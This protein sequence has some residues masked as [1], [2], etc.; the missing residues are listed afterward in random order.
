M[1]LR[2]KIVGAAIAASLL[3]PIL[4]F[5]QIVVP[6]PPAP[7]GGRIQIN[8]PLGGGN[9]N[10]TLDGFVTRILNEVVVPVGAIILVIAIIYTGFLFV[11][12]QGNPEDLKK[13]K[14]AFFYTLIGGAVLLGASVL[15]QLIS[16]T[17]Q[18]LR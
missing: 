4:S 15:A 5:A 10:S 8:N 11:T 14:N 7:P 18:S 16:N 1:N 2:K 17:I 12:A 13:A 6:N 9:N 3:L